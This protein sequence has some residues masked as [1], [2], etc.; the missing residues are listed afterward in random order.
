MPSLMGCVSEDSPCDTPAGA[1]P[2]VTLQFTVVTRNATGPSRADDCD[3][4]QEGSA[5]ENFINMADCQFLL[6]DDDR[7][8]LRPIFPEVTGSDNAAYTWYSIKAE[9]TERYFTDKVNAGAPVDF[10]IMVI[11]NSRS[12]SGQ[13]FGLAPGTTTIDDI[14]AQRRTYSVAPRRDQWNNVNAWQPSISYKKG[15]PMAGL[16]K[17]SVP[18]ADLKRSTYDNPVN[19]SQ[20]LPGGINIGNQKDINM[21]RAMSKIE[22]VDKIDMPDRYDENQKR[23]LVEKVELVG[24]FDR[25]TIVPSIGVAGSWPE[26]VSDNVNVPTVP[27]VNYYTKPGVFEVSAYGHYDPM[28]FAFDWNASENSDGYPVY[29]GYV[30]E[31]SQEAIA[32]FTEPYIAITLSN[33]DGSDVYSIMPLKLAKYTDGVAGDGIEAL[34]RNHIYRYEITGVNSEINLIS[35]GYTVC[36]WNRPTVDIPTFE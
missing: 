3:A 9:I 13:A 27:S 29:S 4:D 36:D 5:A 6:F 12:L 17:F 23:I 33:N 8:L 7:R 35:V 28:M 16:Q 21:L 19:L 20:S 26:Y 18:A 25:G 24:Y 30:P 15:I 14:A 2:T 1:D 11:A 32:G 10:Y 31:Y 34:L 22:I